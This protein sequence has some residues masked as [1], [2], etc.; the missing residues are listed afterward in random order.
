MEQRRGK[1][2]RRYGCGRG[3]DHNGYPSRRYGGGG[4]LPQLNVNLRYGCGRAI[5]EV[6][7]T[8]NKDDVKK[9]IQDEL[10]DITATLTALTDEGVR[11]QD[12]IAYWQQRKITAQAV[13]SADLS[14]DS[15]TD[16]LK[17]RDTP[18]P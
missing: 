14:A 8:T 4:T 16:Y 10:S 12:R 11:V 2:P 15:L 7:K 18:V 17:K 1:D 9:K 6:M 13:I 5:N 3:C